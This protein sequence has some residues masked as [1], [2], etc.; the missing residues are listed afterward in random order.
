MTQPLALVAGLGNPGARY[1]P[2]RHN[3]GFWFVD[4]VVRR[5][6]GSFR[7]DTRFNG[8]VAQ[9]EVGGTRLTLLKPATFMNRSGQ[10]V[11]TLARYFK[12]D[13]EQI[14]IV[15]DEI[16]LPAGAA[17]LKTG[18]GP[19]GHNGLK[20]IIAQLGNNRGFH[21]LRLG[22]GH[23]GERDQVI[24]YVLHRPR[25]EEQRQIEEAMADAMDVFELVAGGDMANAMQRLH[26]K[27]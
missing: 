2:T 8:E 27:G 9:V 17:R 10:S 22:V 7:L 3:A 12:L 5:H 6:G 26:T 14:L 18:G 20:D 25:A 1:D 11:A 13:V 16:D 24:D 15:H 19:G 23:P 21:R 4:E